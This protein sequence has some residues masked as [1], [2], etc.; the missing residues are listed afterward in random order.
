MINEFLKL[1]LKCFFAV[2][3]LSVTFLLTHPVCGAAVYGATACDAVF[4]DTLRLSCDSA[5]CDVHY[6]DAAV[7]S[8]YCCSLFC[9]IVS[10]VLHYLIGQKGQIIRHLLYI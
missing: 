7:Y 5:V 3:I 8:I 4:G 2:K 9:C 1:F 10:G 6:A